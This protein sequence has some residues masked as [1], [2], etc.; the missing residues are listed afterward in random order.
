MRSDPA[1]HTH[2][3]AR[4]LGAGAFA[5]ARQSVRVSVLWPLLTTALVLALLTGV[6]SACSHEV[7]IAPPKAQQDTTSQRA[8]GAQSALDALVRALKDRSRSAAVALAAPGTGDVLA[9]VES[10]AAA[11][12]VGS[13]TMRYVDDSGL[14]TAAQRADLGPDA[15][16]G[17]VQLTYRF[18]GFDTTPA[19]VDARVVFVPGAERAR[20]AAFGGG[21]R[22]PLWLEDQLSVVRAGRTLVSV[23]GSSAGRYPGLASRALTQVR[24]VLPGWRGPLLVEVPRTQAQLDGL[25]DAA[26]GEYDNI[27]AVTTTADG[28]LEAGAPVRVFVNPAVFDKLKDR[29][30]Q[31]VISHEATHVATGATFVSMPTWL[32]EGF[33]DF[34]ALDDAGVPVDVAAAQILARIRKDGVPD[35]LPT[36]ADLDPTA[37]GLGATYEEA[38]LACRFL[39][40]EYGTARL[41]RFYDVVSGGAPAASAFARVLGT[42]QR[43]FV[44]RWQADL[45]RLVR[46]AG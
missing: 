18:D 30:A 4:P 28:S 3:G 22:T 9:R 20:I 13:L 21:G 11:L 26:S 5:H 31:V 6:L 35:R 38:W 19:R 39:G 2:E 24:R 34:V 10:N 42:S 17:T 1:E 32:L 37:N 7:D 41:V 8:A 43:Q 14:L 44:T 33:A 46:V 23:A 40:Q 12:R 29:G 15:W 27:A 36:T 45:R 16:V 25:L